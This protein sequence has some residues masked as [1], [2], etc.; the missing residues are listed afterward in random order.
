MLSRGENK[1]PAPAR[2]NME[3]MRV[4]VLQTKH[5]LRNFADTIWR[6][7]LQD[8]QHGITHQT[9][10]TPMQADLQRSGF[11]YRAVPSVSSFAVNSAARAMS[12]G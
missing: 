6:D 11:W 2:H 7:G 9:K 1:R 5:F 10:L 12:C 4:P 8:R 3:S